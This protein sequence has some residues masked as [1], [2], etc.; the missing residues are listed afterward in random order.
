M[1]AVAALALA[2]FRKGLL[3]G[4]ALGAA[5]AVKVPYALVGAGLLWALR[6]ARRR[7]LVLVLSAAAVL[8]AGYAL[9]GSTA[10]TDVVRRGGK[11]SWNTPW[12]LLDP[13]FGHQPPS[14][15]VTPLSVLLGGC[16]AALLLRGLPYDPDRPAWL[17]PAL[18]V[19]L[20]WLVT[21]PVYFPWYE[22]L[23]FPLIALA[24]ASRLDWLNLVRA[25][26]ATG[27]CLPGVTFQQSSGWLRSATNNGPLSYVIPTLMAVLAVALVAAVTLRIRRVDGA[28]GVTA[29]NITIRA[30]SGPRV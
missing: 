8:A 20:A 21:T 4:L 19:G 9:A 28:A 16:L 13:V 17:H 2:G 1:F 23:V 30:Q 3:S 27:A 18:A 24:P 22:A 12:T 14:S 25:L 29:P 26:V 10:L 15:L 7:L 5:A 11:L 6:D